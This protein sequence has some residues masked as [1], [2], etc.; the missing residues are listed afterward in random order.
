MEESSRQGAGRYDKM[1]TLANHK[2]AKWP[3]FVPM[4]QT[5]G[6]SATVPKI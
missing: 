2:M 6:P 5:F 3:F 4:Y 1:L